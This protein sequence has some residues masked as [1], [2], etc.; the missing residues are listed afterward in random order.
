[1][2]GYGNNMSSTQKTPTL[3]E[4][5]SGDEERDAVH[6]AIV[7]VTAAIQLL[8]GEHIGLAQGQDRML[9]CR[10]SKKDQIGIVD[11]FL[12]APVQIGQQF[13]LL[14]YPNTVTSLK[15]HWTHPKFPDIK[16]SPSE[17][18]LRHFADSF[19]VDYEHMMEE[20][21]EAIENDNSHTSIMTLGSSN[22]V[23]YDEFWGHYQMVTG[24]VLESDQ[25]S[26]LYF[27]CTC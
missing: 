6:I 10:V 9:V 23:D 4:L 17:I 26:E 12:K 19:Y 21:K 15:H 1:M 25:T 24:E 8:P 5:I 20:V 22:E 11:P 2:K 3:G 7:P 13:Y 18:W 27:R 16:M 14:L